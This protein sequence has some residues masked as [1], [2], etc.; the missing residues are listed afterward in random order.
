MQVQEAVKLAKEWVAEVY[1]EEGISNV[2]LEEVE[3]DD[4]R[5]VWN[6]TLGFS[7]Q[8]D[9]NAVA[10]VMDKLRRSYKIVS[11]SDYNGKVLSLRNRESNS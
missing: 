10:T 11:V 7:R 2:G 1:S 3:F 5:N 8:W 4:T 9:R 6:I